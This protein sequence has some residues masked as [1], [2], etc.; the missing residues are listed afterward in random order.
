MP[1]A[2]APRAVARWRP[3]ENPERR[4][5]ADRTR[6]LSEQSNVSCLARHNFTPFAELSFPQTEEIEGGV[7]LTPPRLPIP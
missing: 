7:P 1:A 4:N 6:A 5:S 2:A 3:D